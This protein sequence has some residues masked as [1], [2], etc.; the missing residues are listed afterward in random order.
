MK[1]RY[2][3]SYITLKEKQEERK[4]RTIKEWRGGREREEERERKREREWERGR[5]ETNAWNK[6]K[7]LKKNLKRAETDVAHHKLMR[8]QKKLILEKK[9]IQIQ[10]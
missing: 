10:N 9:K 8:V 5:K 1:E 7:S 4:I 6:R 2:K 3:H